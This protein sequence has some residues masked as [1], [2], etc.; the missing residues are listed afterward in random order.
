[1]NPEDVRELMKQAQPAAQAMADGAVQYEASPSGALPGALVGSIAGYGL[2]AL[3][4]HYGGANPFVFSG[5]GAVGGGLIGAGLGERFS[6]AGIRPVQQEEAPQEGVEKI[7]L[8]GGLANIGSKVLGAAAA[9]P[10][11]ATTI[12]G[13]VLGAGTGA[14]AGGE[15]NR[16]TGALVGGG[17]GA[18]G[19]HM[20]GSVKGIGEGV[21]NLAQK[22][23]DKLITGVA[24]PGAN[25]ASGGA[26]LGSLKRPA[27]AGGAASSDTASALK[28]LNQPAPVAGMKPLG[29]SPSLGDLIKSQGTAGAAPARSMNP[30]SVAAPTRDALALGDLVQSQKMRQIMNQAQAARGGAAPGMPALPKP[31]IKVMH[32]LGSGM[33][34]EAFGA[35]LLAGTRALGSRALGG[36]SFAAK[37]NPILGSALRGGTVGGVVGAGHGAIHGAMD[38]QDTILGSMACGGAMGAGLGAGAGA[39]SHKLL[40]SGVFG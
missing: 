16:L 6:P 15:G 32:I 39:L 24:T 28:S 36:V 22:G 2:G 29:P 11:A 35:G 25:V 34:K 3:A 23:S 10:K 4:S 31:M 5:L 20:L 33:S 14:I 9:N 13:G 38:S 37:N 8:F 40:A 7:A 1:M 18:V 27:V 30:M 21:K 26:A 17:L 19:G 12:A